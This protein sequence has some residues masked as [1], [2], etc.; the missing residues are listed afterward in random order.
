MATCEKC[1][2]I[3]TV[4][5]RPCD[6][7]PF[8]RLCKEKFPRSETSV[9]STHLNLISLSRCAGESI[10]LSRDVIHPQQH[11]LCLF[12]N[13]TSRRCNIKRRFPR[14]KGIC[15]KTAIGARAHLSACIFLW[16]GAIKM[17]EKFH[18]MRRLRHT[19]PVLYA[20]PSKIKQAWPPQSE[21]CALV[22]HWHESLNFPHMQAGANT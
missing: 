17:R 7:D 14:E 2:F 18:E 13:F 15:L 20:P 9:W 11:H 19:E 21:R 8:I 10:H 4:N 16:Q 6:N 5:K 12:C 22:L 1:K 3:K